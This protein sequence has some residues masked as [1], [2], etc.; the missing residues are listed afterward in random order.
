[1][2]RDASISGLFS[3]QRG[4]RIAVLSHC[5]LNEN[6]RYLG[7]AGRPGCVR[8]IAER[9]IAADL[10]IVQLPCPEQRAWGGVVKRWLLAAY[11]LRER[12]P[13]LYGLRRILLFGFR[14]HTKLVYRKLAGQIAADLADYADS[15]ISVI[16][17]VGV[18]GSPSCGVNTTMNLQRAFDVIA[19]CPSICPSRDVMNARLRACTE[20]G[21]GLF[22]TELRRALRRRN[23]G[24]PFLA[25]DLFA[26]LDGKESEVDFHE[27]TG[28]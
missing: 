8:E 4:R 28:H 19:G 7:G 11:G 21:T 12:S 3:D 15:G 13:L 27:L 10:G 1:M 18:D 9:C 22:V 26:E 20:D 5:L 6:T 16:G 2:V 25:H 17:I 23:V 14:L 24:V